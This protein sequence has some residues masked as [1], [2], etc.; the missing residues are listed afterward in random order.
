MNCRYACPCIVVLFLLQLKPCLSGQGSKTPAKGP[1]AYLG[2][3]T[4]SVPPF[5]IDVSGSASIKDCDSIIKKYQKMRFSIQSPG[6]LHVR[7]FG[8]EIPIRKKFIKLYQEELAC[9][10]SET[11]NNDPFITQ[12]VLPWLLSSED[13]VVHFTGSNISPSAIKT[14]VNNG[15][16]QI[17][18]K[19]AAG[20]YAH[21]DISSPEGFTIGSLFAV[22]PPQDSTIGIPSYL[23]TAE[24]LRFIRKFVSLTSNSLSPNINITLEI[25]D[26]QNPTL[27]REP[28]QS[29]VVNGA[30]QA[31]E[32]NINPYLPLNIITDSELTISLSGRAVQA[33]V[34]DQTHYPPFSVVIPNSVFKVHRRSILGLT[35]DTAHD[36]LTSLPGWIALV[37][38]VILAIIGIRHHIEEELKRDQGATI[39]QS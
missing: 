35:L 39:A 10:P 22:D 37:E 14:V 29:L 4:F 5:K 27:I 6:A 24:G 23:A 34:G 8:D 25:K 20:S 21:S 18:Y 16:S 26:K 11:F 30:M 1:E 38:A 12:M 9:D 15:G 32:W 17:E 31:P 28:M 19:A 7:L 3:R 13:A 2:T 33:Y 36:F